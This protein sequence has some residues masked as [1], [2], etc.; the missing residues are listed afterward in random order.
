M[1][2][3]CLA[4]VAQDMGAPI[5]AYVDVLSCHF[6]YFSNSMFISFRFFLNISFHVSDHNA[7]G[8]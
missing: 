7:L 2:V 3:A 5:A 6:T 1:V 4:E 8:T